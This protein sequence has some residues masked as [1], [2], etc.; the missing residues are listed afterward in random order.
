MARVPKGTRTKAQQAS[1]SANLSKFR[2]NVLNFLDTSAQLRLQIDE[3]FRFNRGGEAQWDKGDRDALIAEKRPVESF[4]AC[5]PVV[6]FLSGYEW[7]RRKDGVYYPR[8]T[9][10]ET[11]GRLSTAL[12]RYAMDVGQGDAQLHR[13]FRKGAIGGHA[14]LYQCLNYKYTDD[15]VEGDLDF[16]VL[17]ENSFGYSPFSRRY[18]RNDSDYYFMMY[19]LPLEEAQR[20]WKNHENIL[21]PGFIN[22]WYTG[23]DATTGVP[24][25]VREVFYKRETQQVRIIRY[26]YRKPVEVVLLA[27]HATQDYQRM[28]DGK[29]ADQKL[30][31]IRDSAGAAAASQWQ[32]M[33]ADSQTALINGQTGQMQPF[34]TPDEAQQALDNLTVQAGAAATK[35]FEIVT[36]PTTTL[37]LSH[38]VGWDELDDT[39]SPYGRTDETG[40]VVDVDWRFPFVT[41]VP[42][43]DTDDFLSIKGV[44]RD[45]KDPQRNINWYLSTAQ[46]KLV[47]GPKG[48]LWVLKGEHTDLNRLRAE[49]SRAGFVGEYASKLPDYIP[50]PPI[51]QEDLVMVQ[52]MLEAIMRITGI[53][54]ELLGQTTQKTVSGR[55][56]Q[57]R[58]AGG[59]VGVSSLLMNWSA[60]QKYF[61]ELLIRR[62]QQYYSVGK[63]NRII[64]DDQRMAKAMGLFGEQQVKMSDEAVYAMLKRLKK[65][66]FDVIVEF[67]EHAPTARQAVVSQMMQFMAAGMPIPPEIIIEAS[68]VPRKDEIQ[69]VLKKQGMGPPNPEL[70]KALSAGQGQTASQPD[71]V[72]R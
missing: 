42:Y 16:E 65:I 23:Q 63:M 3:D 34:V 13:F 41:F 33:T 53:N 43:Q 11:L 67:A 71:G 68:D 26:F 59:L 55:S 38:L 4:N 27:N 51:A 19:W 18:D 61:Y 35:D 32:I 57:A 69:A 24:T 8:G 40:E 1:A 28:A 30:Q 36:R 52:T 45:I 49:V 6:N 46:D 54:A 66:D 37:R 5:A 12:S 9:E 10:D 50:P 22:D 15:L 29:E 47:R 2:A 31:E 25:Q 70:A 20:Q 72:N 14:A 39:P 60:S 48:M 17:P 21:A 58:Q 7:E 56:I 44:V 64:G 62:I